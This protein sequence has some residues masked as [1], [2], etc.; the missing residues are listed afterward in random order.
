MWIWFAALVALIASVVVTVAVRRRRTEGGLDLYLGSSPAHARTRTR[1]PRSLDDARVSF[2][3]DAMPHRMRTQHRADFFYMVADFPDRASALRFLRGCEVR[4]ERAYVIAEN[5]QGNLGKDLI[6]IFEEARG[7][8]VEIAERS[9][10]PRI[11]REDCARCGYTVLPVDGASR[12]SLTVRGADVRRYV[13]LDDLERGGNGFRCG[14]C[15]AL[16]CAHCYRA[17]G[18]EQRSDGSLVIHCWLCGAEVKPEPY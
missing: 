6:M 5:P 8:F 9:P 12:S 4:R 10:A 7:N 14:S 15:A 16:A 17:T 11:S 18:P 3:D 1:T 2:P 13:A